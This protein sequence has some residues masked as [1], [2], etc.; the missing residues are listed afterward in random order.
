MLELSSEAQETV[1]K[2]YTMR[3]RAESWLGDDLL[4]DDIPVALGEE[5]RDAS[6]S[7]P[8]QVSLTIPRVD[9]GVS[10]DPIDAKHPLAPWG[11]RLRIEVGIDIRPSVTEWFPRGWFLI[12]ES[13]VSG[14]T[15]SVSASG[16]LQ[17]IDEARFLAPFQPAGTITETIRSLVE[18]ALPVNFQSLTDRA[19]PGEM[20]WDEDRLSALFEVLDVWPA[21][22]RV[23]SEGVLVV[24]PPISETE[25]DAAP[26]FDISDQNEGTV[27]QWE[28]SQARDGAATV[29]AARCEDA[30]GEVV[31]ALAYDQDPT[32]ALYHAGSFNP[33]SVPEFFFSPLLTSHAECLKTAKSILARR[34]RTSARKISASRVVPHPALEINDVVAITG[35]GFTNARAVIDR[36]SFPYQPGR[37]SFSLRLL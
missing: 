12:T 23:D 15:V 28:A 29:I 17:L 13:G 37:M 22:A 34:R 36:F 33:L 11:Q 7:V 26:V 19:V 2:S 1:S 30:D 3:V 6:L 5:T 21:D 4:A 10:Y 8:E 20:Q 31:Q 16:L 35:A 18:P 25:P 24:S 32:S 27:V 14:D 9:R